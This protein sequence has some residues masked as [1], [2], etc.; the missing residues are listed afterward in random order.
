MEENLICTDALS[1]GV[2][3]CGRFGRTREKSDNNCRWGGV[4]YAAHRSA[5]AKEDRTWPQARRAVVAVLR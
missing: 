4:D 2:R 3:V 1:H 5:L